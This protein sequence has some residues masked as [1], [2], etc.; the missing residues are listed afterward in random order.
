MSSFIGHGLSGVISKQCIKTRLSPRK[1]RWLLFLSVFLAILP[2]LDVLVFMALKPAGMVPHRGFS[3]TLLFITAAAT[4]VLAVT[5]KIFPISRIRLFFVYFCPLFAHLALD[6]LMGA[7]PPVRF[8]APVINTGFLSPVKL[9]P[10]AFYSTT[11]GGLL[12][13]LTHGPTR[14]GFV[15]EILIFA[16]VIAFLGVSGES[17]E[18]RSIKTRSLAVSA[19]ALLA[20]FYLYNFVVTF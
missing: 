9:V 17:E 4:F 14:L 6:Y 18:T 11:F 15:L 19:L 12:G 16:P 5:Y 1:E 2:D 7:G 10:C 8:F 20:T 13:L 3:H